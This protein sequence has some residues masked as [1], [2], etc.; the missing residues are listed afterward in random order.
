MK[1]R[2]SARNR[3]GG[4]VAVMVGLSAVLLFGFLAVVVDL[5]HVYIAKTELQNA[6][7]AAALSGAKD[8]DGTAAGVASGVAKAI[9]IAAQ[10][11]YDFSTPV[12]IT[13]S[14]ISV[15]SC[16]ADAC[17]V[18]ASTVTTDAL[19][20]DKTFMKVDTAS[21]QLSTWI[22]PIFNLVTG[23]SY[24]TTSTFGLAVAGKYTI[25]V[26]PLGICELTPDD[27]TNPNV[28][29]LGFERGV[30]YKVSD[31]NPLGPGTPF[32]IDPTATQQIACDGSASRSLP[33]MCT[34][35]MS[36]TPVLGRTVFTNT[37]ISDPQLE[38]L[39]S[40]FDVFNSK[41]KC[42]AITAPPDTNI[43][44]YKYNDLAAGSPSSWIKTDPT[45]QSIRFTTVGAAYLPVPWA[46]RTFQDYG[47]LWSASRPTAA[48]GDTTDAAVSTRWTALY[49]AGA[50]E[51]TSY[52]QPSPYAQSSGNFFLAPSNPGKAG[53]RIL[54]ITIVACTAAGGNCRPAT[55]RGIGKFIMQKKANTPGD[56]EIYVEFAGLLPT[57]LP[58][59][60][61]RLYR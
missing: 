21:R 5:G 26:S 55:V 25:D 60:D 35:R 20:A 23:G 46:T 22:S 59:S 2:V 54:N 3:Q 33:Y 37:G 7:D 32:W 49:H 31:A 1:T 19:A 34:G 15:G 47:V 50:G 45:R 44:E 58:L 48:A 41:N 6:A 36:F 61:I 18:L 53:R 17:M 16:P 24:A 8:L 40:R 4:A 29:E 38:A 43:K 13:I 9:A 11:N 10:H 56:K 52:P 57:P 51:A 14:N 27:A 42:D 28:K 39:D 30:S 12:S